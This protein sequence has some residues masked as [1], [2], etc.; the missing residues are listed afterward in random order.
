MTRRRPG[1]GL[2][3][4]GVIVTHWT[5]VA[6][7]VALLV[8]GASAASPAALRMPARP[9]TIGPCPPTTRSAA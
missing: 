4:A 6:V 3:L 8:A 7:G 1:S 5:T 9:D 2:I